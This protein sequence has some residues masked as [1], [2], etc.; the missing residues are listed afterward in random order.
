L[1]N[2]NSKNQIKITFKKSHVQIE[3]RK[4]TLKELYTLKKK[5]PKE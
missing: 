2:I 4:K 1:Y 5:Y 3:T